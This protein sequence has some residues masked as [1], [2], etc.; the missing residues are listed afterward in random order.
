MI[1][2]RDAAHVVVDGRQ[3]RD[4][5]LGHVN[6]GED[7]GRFRDARQAGVQDLGIQVIQVQEDV[8]LVRAHAAAFADF[9]GHGA[10]NHV[11]R[12]QILHGRR[13]ALHEALAFGV[14]QIAAFAAGALCDQ[15]AGAVDAGRVE[16]HELHVL[17]RQAGAQHHGVAVAGAG[18]GRGGR[19]V[20]AAVT[21]GGQHHHLGAE[22][23]QLAGVEL[24]RGDA[25]AGAVLHDQ[26]E[27]EVFDEELH[28]AADRLAV[29][30]VQD[31]VTGAVGGGAGA[32][33]RA[34]AEVAGHAAEGAL[35]DLALVGAAEGHAPVFQLING[36]RR[37]A[38][39]VFDGVLVAQPV[40][41]LDG[42]VHVPLPG[43]L[44]HVAERGGDAALGRHGVRAG[45][46]DLGDA[47][48]L[49]ALLGGAEGGAQA[50][51]PGAD[52]DDVVFVID[53]LVSSH[54]GIRL[55]P[56]AGPSPAPDAR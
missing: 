37:V 9:D 20:G 18:V 47:S 48:D 38:D 40:R 23:V 50:G 7:L 19:E 24:K 33:H 34:F 42:V 46:E 3:D 35:I 5:L 52:D 28:L 39:Q 53:K 51:A 27:G 11:A 30:G 41:P 31:G 54:G 12:C 14:G 55:R 10:R 56:A 36:L 21:A 16:L 26:I 45:R 2:R 32:L 4:R 15:A 6:A 29:Q 8:V 25:R 1:V 17:Q 22:L 13:I 43:V 44:A 49:Q